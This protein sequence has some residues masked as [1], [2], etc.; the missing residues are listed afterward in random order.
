MAKTKRSSTQAVP[1][2]RLET[3]RSKR[4]AERTV[5]PFGGQ[6][7]M[8]PRL[9]VVQKHAARK[10]HHDFRLEWGGTLWSWAVPH[11]PSL[12]PDEKRLAVHVEDHPVEYA[13][14]EGL[15]PEGNYGAGAVI[16][17]D[18]GVWV[19]FDDPDTGL[20]TGKLHFELRGYK[21]R[22][23]WTL[24]KTKRGEK[25][26]L[27]FK[28]KDAWA[29]PKG[30]PPPPEES[31]LSGLTVEELRDGGTRA[32]EIRA[33][34][35]KRKAPRKRVDPRGI[36][37]MLAETAETPF[38]TPGW[39]FE[40]KY[41]GYR[42][43]AA[44]AQ[45][46]T[47]LLLSR[48]G[49]DLTSIF[50]DVARAV[51]ALPYDGLVLDGEVVVMD[52]QGKPD[53]HLLQQ[54][55]R[56]RRRA[57]I[58]RGTVELPAALFAFDLLGFEDFDLRPLPLFERKALLRRILPR[59]GPLRFADHVETRGK[60]L[61]DEVRK[62]GLEGIMA[63]KAAAPYRAGRSS[64]WLK[65]VV[66]RA[67]DF[68]VVGYSAPQG[69][70]AGFGALHLAV[71]EASSFVYSGRV[72]TGFTEKQLGQMRKQLEAMRRAK[73]PCTGPIPNTKGDHW[74]EPLWV[75]EVK[76]K[77]ITDDGLLRHPV[78][79]RLRDDKRP[80]E[81]LRPEL[82]HAPDTEPPVAEVASDEPTAKASSVKRDGAA[83][84]APRGL[85]FSNLDKVFWPEERYTKRDLVEFYR[86]VSPWLLPYLRDRPLVLTRFPDGILGKSFYQ[87]NAP[88]FVP[89][90]LRTERIWSESTEREIDYFVCDDLESLLYV[91]NLGAIPLHVWSSRV[92]T[93]QRP[94]WCILDLDPKGAPFADVV[95]IALAIRS[96][97]EDISLP[98][99]VKTSGSTG[100]HVLVPLAGQC[101]YEQSR[102][103][104]LLLARVVHQELPDISTITRAIGARGGKVYLDYL[105]NRHGQLLVAPFS[106]RPLP[107]APVSTPL[108]W[109]EVNGRL[110][111][112]DFTI[113]TVP[114]RLAK[115]KYDPVR[116][117]LA[118]KPDLVS[119]L[120]R[121]SLRLDHASK[122]AEKARRKPAERRASDGSRRRSA[123][124]RSP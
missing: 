8:R 27:L 30:A 97:C 31:I 9:F 59:A 119:A 20:A 18:K 89:D 83:K 22:G 71:H 104:A 106:V 64:H 46:S 50:P 124:R 35:V 17:W 45:D 123:H 34:L 2:D 53:F 47:P 4:S 26:W 67:G 33:E 73:P 84:P 3:Y 114:P 117:I 41:D 10:L 75:A 49:H 92:E 39:I 121:L 65:L 113:R 94:D 118:T 96:L 48:G 56:L 102:Q 122:P 76:Y 54:R 99:Y 43:I 91:A 38:S 24:I 107:G 6:G 40:L 85:T 82:H 15:I 55:A 108:E 51:R 80:E 87:K 69:S 100:L 25:D 88:D 81:C 111:I 60:E 44:R 13:D 14:F 74:V 5:E 1:G 116:P 77:E 115:A 79:V 110:D 98:S 21:L 78:F 58:E 70:R 57:D 95:R 68:V 112:H 36:G 90:W 11:G 52:A 109:K 32:Q 19:P 63:K 62:R 105:Q 29:T 120:S 66:E 12:D 37:L 7:P 86:T 101:T 93:L 72:G 16:V 61:L 103:L 28:K 42:F 23:V